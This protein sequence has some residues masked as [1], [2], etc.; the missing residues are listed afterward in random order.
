MSR[1]SRDWQDVLCRLHIFSRWLPE[2]CKAATWAAAP[3]IQPECQNHHLRSLDNIL[4]GNLFDSN[5]HTN[6]RESSPR[7][8][9]CD[10]S[11]TIKRT[12]HPAYLTQS[13]L[14]SPFS[15]CT[16]YHSR[17]IH[18][19]SKYHPLNASSIEHLV[20][21]PVYY[22]TPLIHDLRRFS[23][24][25]FRIYIYIPAFSSICPRSAWATVLQPHTPKR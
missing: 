3:T 23:F 20:S 12:P 18:F 13:S 1:R 21:V 14:E 24:V 25:P 6:L 19:R 15:F 4:E 16:K 22:H 17:Y 8:D 7:P 5:K 9:F 10:L 11:Q 2:K